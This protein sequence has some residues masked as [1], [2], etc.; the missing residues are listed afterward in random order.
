MNFTYKELIPD[1]TIDIF[2]EKIKKCI[3][4]KTDYE[5]YVKGLKK[6]NG[7]KIPDKI[8]ELISPTKQ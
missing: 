2:Y 5:H 6:L 4:E 7:D 3:E 1:E 8:Q